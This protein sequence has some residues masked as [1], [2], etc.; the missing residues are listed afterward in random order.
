MGAGKT[1]AV[2][3]ASKALMA[4]G[5]RVAVV[6]NDQGRYL[7]D[8]AFS[9]LSEVPS[10]EVT[11]GCFCCRYDDF[12]AVLAR[13]RDE[14]R[15]DVVFAES[16]GSCADVVVTVVGPLREAIAAATGLDGGRTDFSVFADVRLLSAFLS[17]QRLPFSDDVCYVYGRQIAE[18]GLLVLNKTDLLPDDALGALRTR[19]AED[20]GP[21]PT[22]AAACR[23]PAGAEAWLSALESGSDLSGKP[24]EEIDYRR[25]GAGE[26]L[27]AWFDGT[28]EISVPAGKGGAVAEALEALQ[29]ELRR[30]GWGIGHLKAAVEG[31]DGTSYKWSAVA[32]RS[33][34]TPSVPP[35]TGS[36]RLLLN[37]RVETGARDLEAAVRSVL[38]SEFGRAGAGL[39]WTSADAFHPG[40]PRPQRGRKVD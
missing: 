33:P 13:L 16:V 35:C 4:R 19:L 29:E 30:R 21:L 1:T 36:V 15:P 23:E 27:L 3:N 14:L 32:L 8:S 12:E 18:A 28:A 26:A 38:E 31:E 22:L 10:V 6:T 39:R 2:I 17:G 34:S 25:Y 11:G 24:L 37:A 7:V 9:R 5:K 40:E 20:Y